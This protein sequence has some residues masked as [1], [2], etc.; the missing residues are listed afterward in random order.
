[1]LKNLRKVIQKRVY[2]VLSHKYG[3]FMVI[4]AAVIL[5]VAAL[6][7]GEVRKFLFLIFQRGRGVIFRRFPNWI[8]FRIYLFLKFCISHCHII[9]VININLFK[10]IISRSLARW[11]VPSSVH[12][13]FIYTPCTQVK[14]MYEHVSGLLSSLCKCLS[15]QNDRTYAPCTLIVLLQASWSNWIQAGIMTIKSFRF[16]L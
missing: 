12:V 2:D 4:A 9:N 1:M 10:T 15:T 6:H 13:A 16:H 14:K 11:T 3:I 5:I 7:F 8:D